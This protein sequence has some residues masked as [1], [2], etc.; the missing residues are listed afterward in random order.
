[1]SAKKKPTCSDSFESYLLISFMRNKS[2]AELDEGFLMCSLRG[3]RMSFGK[4][5]SISS[6]SSSFL[7]SLFHSNP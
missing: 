6:G 2:R 1:M 3:T 5:V 7:N 4:M